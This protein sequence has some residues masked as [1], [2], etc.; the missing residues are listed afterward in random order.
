LTDSARHSADIVVIGAGMVGAAAAL[1]LAQ[2]G[3]SVILVEARQPED[4]FNPDIIDNRVSALTRASEKLLDSLNVWSAMQSMRVKPY[5]D[6]RVWDAEGRG[7]IHFDAA[8][9]AEPSLGHIVENQVTQ[10]AL[11]HEIRQMNNIELICPDKVQ[12]VARDAGKSQVLLESGMQ[13]VAELVVVA[14]GKNSQ[15]RGLLDINTKGWLYDQHAVV[16]TVV[17]EQGHQNCA[18]QRF[19]P[20]GPLAFLPL[21]VGN[22]D[23]C[24]IVWSTSPENAEQLV[25]KTDTEFC[26]A[27][28]EAS[29]YRLGNIT[30]VERRGVFPLEL[31]HA[32]TYIKEG[33]VL[34]GDAAHAVH[35][36]AGQG[37][38]LGF[39]DVQALLDNVCQAREQ[40]RNLGGMRGLRQY[41]R[42]RKASNL[43]MLAAMDGFKRL[44]SNRILPL[45]AV[46][47]AG[48]SFVNNLGALKQ[49][50]VRYAMG[51]D[52][53]RP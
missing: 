48:L 24:S 7:E 18:W 17:V 11:W 36:L 49:F 3:F 13:L 42:R 16:A 23:T 15:T 1:G 14:D 50:F 35:P 51:L 6:M 37:V 30:S 38:N 34:V 26:Q 29:E 8:E 19:M 46:R 2:K 4:S 32:E 43:T 20:D 44:F 52:Q 41:E 53:F 47:N 33:F 21:G 45:V 5:T 31:K 22:Q 28:G 12:Q 9:L 39:L 25:S 27:L 40:G 10:V